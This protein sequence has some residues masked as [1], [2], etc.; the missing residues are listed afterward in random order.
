MA[1]RAALA[2]TTSPRSSRRGLDVEGAEADAEAVDALVAAADGDARAA[3][4][5]LEVA[6]AL[7]GGPARATTAR[8]P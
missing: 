8:R 4:T 3:L 7:A 2:T 5:T 1:A 6:V